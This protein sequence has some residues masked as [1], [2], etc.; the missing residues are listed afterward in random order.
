MWLYKD[1]NHY[2]GEKLSILKCFLLQKAI[3]GHEK[4]TENTTA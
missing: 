3:Q 1:Q 4:S 2:H